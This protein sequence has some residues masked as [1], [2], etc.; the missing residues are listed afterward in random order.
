[1]HFD[2]PTQ[3][4]VVSDLGTKAVGLMPRGDSY[5][6]TKF[7]FLER[8]ARYWCEASFLQ[9]APTFDGN[10]WFVGLHDALYA[11]DTNAKDFE[12]LW[13]VSEIG[14]NVLEVSRSKTKLTM[15]VNMPGKGFEKW[16]YDLPNLVLRSRNQVKGWHETANE[17]Q[18]LS[19]LSVSVAYSIAVKQE[20]I[21]KDKPC[22][23]VEI[24]DHE[25]KVGE[26]RICDETIGLGKPQIVVDQYLV[27]NYTKGETTVV[28]YSAPTKE[29]ALFC[30][31]GTTSGNVKLDEKFLTVSD[32]WG[33]IIVFDYREGIL[34]KNLRY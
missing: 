17:N 23:D 21:E 2:Q 19:N 28:L 18:F 31:R 9:F 20:L 12:A 30:L 33:R 27:I 3:K 25:T 24:Y 7:D 14:G 8:R 5:R 6:L 22:F 1:V 4:F 16:S 11:I 10:L 34:R 29:T 13:R 26:F 15:L 32:E